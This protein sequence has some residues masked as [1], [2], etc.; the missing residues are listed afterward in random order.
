MMAHM[1]RAELSR[2]RMQLECELLEVKAAAERRSL[3][4]IAAVDE[5][6]GHFTLVGAVVEES[7]HVLMREIDSYLVLNPAAKEVDITINS[8][9]GVVIDGFALVDYLMLLRE[10]GIHVRVTALGLCASMASVIM[11][12]ASERIMTPRAW[13]GI[14]EV[15]TSLA[16]GMSVAQDKMKWVE[17]LQDAAIEMYCSR[18]D[19]TKDEIHSMWARKD[20]MLNADEALAHGLIDR[21]AGLTPKEG[22]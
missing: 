13:I 4:R 1:D 11:Q 3:D 17:R 15:Q 21:I 6:R 5:Q 12:A 2:R 14:H 19:L 16:G 10:R 8:G 7:V 20:V 9:G 22:A 18:S